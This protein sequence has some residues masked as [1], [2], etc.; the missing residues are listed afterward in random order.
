MANLRQRI[1]AT[2]ANLTGSTKALAGALLGDRRLQL[3][4]RAQQVRAAVSHRLARGPGRVRGTLQVLLGRAL[5]G[6]GR[7]T[8]S[9][10]MQAAGVVKQV[11]GTA[12]QTLNS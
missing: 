8:D 3:A 1:A 2:A 4:G 6:T 9:K 12:R 7:A 11:E 5:R 10:D